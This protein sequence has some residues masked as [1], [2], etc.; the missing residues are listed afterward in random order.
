MVSSNPLNARPVSPATGLT[1]HRDVQ[2]V[3]V[4]NSSPE[5]LALAE[6]VLATQHYD[7]VFVESLAHA[8]SRIRSVH[9]DMV[10]LCLRIADLEAFQL[11]S[12]LKLDPETRRIPVVTF[13]AEDMLPGLMAGRDE[14]AEEEE[15]ALTAHRVAALMN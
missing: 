9:P 6:R 14:S 10:V 11:L 7:I 5:I 8:Y 3:V 13:T 12:M 4:V 15:D 1:T 2:T